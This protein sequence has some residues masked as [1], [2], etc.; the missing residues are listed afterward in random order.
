MGLSLEILDI[1]LGARVEAHG[2]LN[3]RCGSAH[4]IGPHKGPTQLFVNQTIVLKDATFVVQ[5]SGHKRIQ[6]QG[7]RSVVAFARG[8]LTAVLDIGALPFKE[9]CEITYNP[10][11]RPHINSFHCRRTLKTCPAAPL[12]FI[13]ADENDSNRT[14]TRLWVLWP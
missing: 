2:N 13:T 6:E 9:L 14:R 1:P 12:A 10:V 8:T 7:V 3:A 11:E 4:P 5:P